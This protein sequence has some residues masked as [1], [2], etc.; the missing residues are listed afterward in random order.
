MSWWRGVDGHARD[1]DASVG[2][3]ESSAATDE[4][5]VR[6]VERLPLAGVET[7]RHHPIR[8]MSL[9]QHRGISHK[10]TIVF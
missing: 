6:G 9:E 2:N 4:L 5:K 3:G 10:I 8:R 7:C 1:A